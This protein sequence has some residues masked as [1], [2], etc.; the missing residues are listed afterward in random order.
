MGRSA[1]HCKS[2]ATYLHD[3]GA[4]RP[5]VVCHDNHKAHYNINPG[6]YKSLGVRVVKHVADNWWG[7]VVDTLVCTTTLLVA[8]L[9]VSIAKQNQQDAMN[10]QTVASAFGCDPFYAPDL[11]NIEFHGDR[12]YFSEGEFLAILLVTGCFLTCTCPPGK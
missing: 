5:P 11:S 7:F 2:A 10:N 12:G 3:R 6:K 8:N 9:Q 4:N 1:G